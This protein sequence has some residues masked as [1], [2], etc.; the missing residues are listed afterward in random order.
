ML[1]ADDHWYTDFPSGS[2][3]LNITE[4]FGIPITR[5]L[6]G[7]RDSVQAAGQKL[8]GALDNVS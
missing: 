4:A 3:I 7:R 6:R 1:V 2:M 8:I 5:T